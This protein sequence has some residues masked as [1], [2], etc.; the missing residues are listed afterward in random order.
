MTKATS[1]D[2]AQSRVSLSIDLLAEGKGFGYL[3]VPHSHDESA[4]GSVQVPIVRIANNREAGPVVLLTGG[5]HGDEYEGPTALMNIAR[6]LSASEVTGCIYIMPALN[7]PAVRAG[8]RTSPI[9][10]GNMNRAFPGDARGSVTA[11]IADFV[12]QQLVLNCDVVID[13]H[14][15]G[16]TLNFAPSVIIHRLEDE[17]RQQATLAAMHAFGAPFGLILEEL[18]P[19]GLL[20]T[21]AESAG[22]LFLSTELGG[23][24]TST[25]TTVGIAQQGVLNVLSHL[26]VLAPQ[27]AKGAQ[28][29]TMTTSEQAFIT[30]LDHGI[31]EFKVDLGQA[32]TKGEWLASI[33]D[34]AR[35]ELATRN[36]HAK[37]DGLLIA[38]HCPGLINRGDCLAVIASDVDAD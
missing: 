8:K 18:D 27:A 7:L 20:D 22:K 31:V 5:N 38:R 19:Q 2:S 28:T 1:G 35:P 32:V 4:W 29:R 16:R 23:G 34:Y 12:Y 25:P 37:C 6:A 13:I 9:D 15:G 24:G 21:A 14:S 33:H 36:Y 3:S 26:N 10:G 30:S 17:Q 11:M